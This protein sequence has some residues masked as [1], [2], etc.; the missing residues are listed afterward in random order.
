MSDKDVKENVVKLTFD[1][2]SGAFSQAMQ[3]ALANSLK[4]ADFQAKLAAK[5]PGAKV[6]LVGNVGNTL[7]IGYGVAEGDANIVGEAVVKLVGATLGGGAGARLGGMAGRRLTPVGMWVGRALGAGGGAYLA[8]KY[9]ATPLWKELSESSGKNA[10]LDLGLARVEFS[11][12]ES[13]RVL[14]PGEQTA[15]S[16]T[17]T[18]FKPVASP[19]DETSI[20]VARQTA[21]GHTEILG[22]GWRFTRDANA[23]HS[24]RN[25]TVKKGESLWQLATR[26]GVTV[27][28]YLRA[29]PQIKHPDLIQEGQ[30]INRPN[31]PAVTNDFDLSIKPEHQLAE[32]GAGD[33]EKQT[34]R[35]EDGFVTGGGGWDIRS[36]A[37]KLNGDQMVGRFVDNTA[38]VASTRILADGWRPGNGNLSE[39]VIDRIP[40]KEGNSILN[41]VNGAIVNS[42]GA[43]AQ[44]AAPTD[45]LVLDLNGDGVMLTDYVSAPVWFDADNDGGS[46]EQTGWVSPEDGIVV[47]DRNGNGTIDNMSEVLSE[48][49]A[50]TS[51][52][53]GAGGEKR[54]KDG[55]AAL[56][57]LDSN[58]DNVFDSR[59]DAWQQVKVWVDANHDGKSWMDANGN[60]R[61]DPGERSELKGLDALG[62][63]RIDLDPVRQSGEV[64]DGNE[65][66]ARGTFV[67]HG[68]TKEA[69]AANL[70]V[71]P[72][73]NTF[74]PSGSGTIVRT[75]QGDSR[76]AP[77]SAYVAGS[78]GETIDVAKKG[79][80]NGVGG[81]GN[82]IL[83]GDAGNNWL[84]GGAGADRLEGGN[85]DDV[86][87][88]DADD[89]LV[90]GGAGTDIV[91]VVGDR[92][93]TLNLA[94]SEVE[95]VQG[96]RGNDVLVGGGRSSVFIAG[97]DGDDMIV[98]GAGNDALSGEDGDDVIDGGAGND[99]IRGHRGRDR[100]FGGEGDDY[101]DGG[102]DDDVLMGGAGNDV[103]RGGG[104]DDTID[105]ADGID[106]IE[107]SGR[108]SEYRIV[109]G[110][111]GI[112]ISD[113]VAGRDGTDFVKNVE[114]ANFTDVTLV[115]I[116][117]SSGA[118]LENPMPVKDVLMRDK[119]GKRLERSGVHLIAKEQLLANDI[120]FQGDA[121]H[122]SAVMEA[123]GGTVTL[124]DAG[125]VLFTPDA[126]FT[127][128]MS[129]KYTVAD[130]KDNPAALVTQVST[131]EHA[132]ARAAV[133]LK[134]G[135]LPSDDL[136]T[137]QWYLADTN[138]LPAWRDYSGKGVRIGQFETHGSFGNSKEVL[139]YRHRDLKDNIDPEWLA[140]ATPGRRAGEGSDGKISDHATLV[141][142]VMVASRNGAGG[143]GVA[144][145]ATL[146]GHWLDGKDM[147]S[148]ARM[149]EYDVVNHSWGSRERFT[150]RYSEAKIGDLPREYVDALER[151]RDGLGTVIVMAAGN[152]RAV[153]G[154]A[155]YS[156]L[157]NSRSSMIVG[158]INA[159]TDLGQFQVHQQPFSSRGASIL[160]SAPGSNVTSTSS[161]QQNANGSTFGAD[162][163]T[164]QG[165]SFATP[166][167]SGIVALML[168]ANPRLGYRDVQEILALSARKVDDSETDWQING[169]TRW[170]GG[171]MHVSHDYGYGQVDARAAV[172]L[173]ET[174]VDRQVADNLYG[175]VKSP[176]SGVL[177]RAIPDGNAAGLKHTLG[178]AGTGVTTE[179]VEVRIR[180][181]HARPGDLIIKLISPSGTESILMDRPGRIPGDAASRGDARFD[182]SNT[183]D[184]VFGSARHRG[185]RADGNWTLQVIDTVSGDTGILHDWSLNAMGRG[186]TANDQ[187]VYTDEF[188]KLAVHGRDV[189]DDTNGGS[190][191]INV[192]A[193]SSGSRVDLAAGNA[194]I[195]GAALTIRNSANFTNLVGGEFDDALTGNDGTNILVGGR[196]NDTL[197]G[198][199][200]MDVLFGGLGNDTLTGGTD[201]DFFVIERD[202]GS[203]DT[204]ADFAIGEDCIVLSGLGAN[205]LA[206]LKLSQAGSDTRIE[207]P[208][209]QIMILK[210]VNAGKLTSRNF[211]T[212]EAGLRPS[213]VIHGKLFGFGS[214]ASDR[215]QVLPDGGANYWAGDG[216][217]RVFGGTGNDIVYGG[218]G[219]DVLVG[220]TSTD[221]LLG[222]NDVLHGG[223]GDDVVR[224]GPGNDSLWGDEGLD[225]L[226]G[227]AGDDTLYLEGDQGLNEFA[228]GDLF[229]RNLNLQ[230]GTL[231]G[232]AVAGG[233]GNDRFVVVE[234][235]SPSASNGLMKNLIEDF[236]V[237]NPGEKIDLSQIRAVSSFNDLS[238]SNIMI[239]GQQFL[240]VFLGR[241]ASGTQYVT[242]RGVRQ[243]QLSARNF[244]F[245]QPRAQAINARL[246]GTGGNDVLVGDAGGNTLDGGAGADVMEGRTGD[247][248][249]VVDNP[250]DVVKELAGGGYDTVKSSISYT[251]PDE[252][253]ALALIG[254]D[255]I[256]GT[257][258]A[259][260]NRMVGNDADNR[261]DGGAGADLLVGGKGNDTYIVDHTSDRVVEY[262]GQ[263][264]DTVLSSVSFTLGDHLENLTLTGD[265]DING[266]GNALSNRL[267]GNTADNRL[268]GGAGDD[269]LDGGAGNDY[270]MGGAGSDTYLFGRGSGHDTIFNHD[271]GR[272]ARDVLQ[273]GANVGAD[274][275]WFRR[276]GDDLEVS[277]VGSQDVATV[278][279]WYA[280]QEFRLDQVKLADGRT[281]TDIQVDQLVDAMATFAP[282]AAGQSSLPN[283]YRT[284]LTPVLAA[285]WQ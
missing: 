70:L 279:Q 119:N 92:G 188:A 240:R 216:D 230:G 132:S 208:E 112:W 197:R 78:A 108:L 36:A 252:V 89:V 135:D 82:D 38:S 22:G 130:A 174:W 268:L 170:N 198:N 64:R 210:N 71:N 140:D 194:T 30:V 165:T 154:N 192:A 136:V 57:S 248:T 72:N 163:K 26:D 75:E 176:E 229:A 253:E 278:R 14:A 106:I 257:G 88:I 242:L 213:E 94:Q 60:G 161:L 190:N 67:Q 162:A 17:A 18:V 21:D 55:F 96:G 222:G 153:G 184:F 180:L 41:G 93:V 149:Q 148:L 29:N 101:L 121:L 181:T 244:I 54:Y 144:H 48:Y 264:K 234:D 201:V 62:I 138:V 263:G 20:D 32:V 169:A 129:F 31:L 117:S 172:R 214:D 187:Y 186:W 178:I 260:A 226:N 104:G 246:S 272:G 27:D 235:R 239:A 167:V 183:L 199:G 16:E 250:G 45:P 59:D 44:K 6:W 265:A 115:D 152:D 84:S 173:A 171:G 151:G 224:G 269:W 157:T 109:P 195:A 79:V 247:D 131:G 97:G 274:Q 99:V 182:G 113:T 185:E 218:A 243:E 34:Q 91:H 177:D 11:L 50:G 200:G 207:L 8:E 114:K 139:D 118:G 39:P 9:L 49:F 80:R 58:R 3:D 262:E 43:W 215:E 237:N 87:L 196:G 146:G 179:H 74:T 245:G 116:P 137:D 156:S 166:I 5:I 33:F 228:N 193:V 227:D 211:L 277:I 160:V 68:Q 261:L 280:G 100:L 221:A 271:E 122:I 254:S 223:T 28:D 24:D 281:L 270:L 284:A 13:P 23:A 111:D 81:Q 127:G 143:V 25:Y 220:E 52:I 77:G 204:I 275:I 202:P 107:L 267:I 238:F 42:L 225:Y 2:G 4:G 120:D 46:L 7:Q 61:L 125:D 164:V 158:A 69:V 251:L 10:I 191:T 285:N 1:I 134:T 147:S 189:L 63:T 76:L 206:R 203:T 123:V 217:D 141:A 233:A 232:A 212:V 73:G 102:T 47:L 37:D 103:L 110:E 40:L 85:G 241:M 219:N 150:L 259:K 258:N 282:P 256:N 142:G 155:N 145:G 83:K 133:F 236:E 266:T 105:G 205:P 209:G 15:I 12:Q 168:E 90:N 159:K 283:D 86:L 51:G 175:A 66:L 65:I 19:H 276:Q 128:F 255:A 53:D 231:T 126:S 249:Y 95:I 56:K 124:T 273:L 98:G 35:V